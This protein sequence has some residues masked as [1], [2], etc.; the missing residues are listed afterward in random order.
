MSEPST[1]EAVREEIAYAYDNTVFFRKHMEASG[2][3]PSD[4]REPADF[5]RLPPT[6]KPH[7]R[8]NFPAGVLAKGYTLNSPHVMRF[9]SSGTSGERLNSAILSYD[10]ARRQASALGVNRRFDELW[11]PGSRP[12]I[13]RFAPPNCSDVECATGFSTMEDR[14]LADGTLVLTVAHD[15]L[16]TP[17]WQIVKAL[18][19]IELYEPDLLVVDPTH[20]AFLT[21]WAR[22]LGRAITSPRR[23]HMVCGYTLMTRVAR[24]QIEE[25]MGPDLP[26]GDMI[27]M[28]E[29]GYLGFECHHGNRHVNN[30]DF[31]MEFIRDGLPVADGETGEMYVTTVDDGLVPRI[32]YATGD[33]FTPL[34]GRCTC[35][36]DLPLVR[37]EGRATH[38]IR[39]ADGRLVTP[40]AVDALVGDAP[41]IDLYKLE[42]DR[43]GACTFRYIPNAA[44]REAQSTALEQR[45]TEALAPNPVRF[46]A[47][48]YIAGERSGKFQPVVS[49]ISAEGA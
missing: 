47:V 5:L 10:L 15:L 46:E 20:F 17:E 25:F 30:R 28:S 9:Q 12:R 19:E 8:R 39:L 14:I 21:R 32:R 16:A 1:F 41:G 31:H 6:S 40:G 2:L 33:H 49:Q 34:G 24:R 43:T 11:R 22:K 42:Q 27:G 38:M 7:Y 4:I 29:L 44:A 13:C 23:L 45:L 26:V 36:S 35:G 37:I 3:L 18:D 48:D